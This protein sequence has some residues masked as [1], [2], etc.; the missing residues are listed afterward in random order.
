MRGA[1]RLTLRG[2]EALAGLAFIAP[3]IVGFAVFTAIPFVASIFL[4]LTNVTITPGRV[5]S[6]FVGLRS[7]VAA[8]TRDVAFPLDLAD[9]LLFVLFSVPM[10]VVFSL[11]VAL[12]L[13]RTLAL[14]GLFRGIYFF[15]VI[16]ISGPVVA[17]LLQTGAS[18]VGEVSRYYIYRV[19]AT[20]PALLSRP[21]LYVFDNL[22]L[23]LWFSGVQTLIYLAGLQKISGQIY[24]AAQMDGASAWESFWKI[25]LPFLRPFILVNTFYTIVELAAFPGN[26]VNV[27]IQRKMFEMGNVYSYSAALAWIFFACLLALMGV[28]YLALRERE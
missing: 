24:E 16:I 15:P 21:L 22:V 3:W 1:R 5:V 17:E 12:L 6:T 9:S 8:F 27:L 2:Q 11:I 10:I 14:R 4:S 26:K 23:I 18:A 19:I 25:T 13:N 7:Y 20:F 28:A